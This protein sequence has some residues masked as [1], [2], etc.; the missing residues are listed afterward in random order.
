MIQVAYKWD[1]FSSWSNQK[2][3]KRSS[4]LFL[5][6]IDDSREDIAHY[7]YIER[8]GSIIVETFTAPPS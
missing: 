6:K 1:V 2:S 4:A 5:E 8:A 7:L 3:K